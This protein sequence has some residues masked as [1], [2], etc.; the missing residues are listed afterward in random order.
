MIALIG[1]KDGVSGW[2]LA[3]EF[4]HLNLQHILCFLGG[5]GL[6]CLLRINKAGPCIAQRQKT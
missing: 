5:L 2:W 6:F 3:L 4:L 1:R